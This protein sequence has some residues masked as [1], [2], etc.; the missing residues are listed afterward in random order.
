V[1]PPLEDLLR[2]PF[3]AGAGVEAFDEKADVFFLD[4]TTRF[5]VQAAFLDFTPFLFFVFVRE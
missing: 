3:S 2:E 4:E 5:R 1:Q